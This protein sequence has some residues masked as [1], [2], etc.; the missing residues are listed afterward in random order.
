MPAADI[1]ALF[2]YGTLMRA[3]GHPM[4]M[5]LGS[6]SLYLGPGRIAARLYNLGSYP[7]AVPSDKARDSVHGDVVKL[8]RPAAT[9][10]WLDKYEGCG[11]EAPEPQAY[12]RVTAPVVLRAGESLNAWVYFYKMPVH[13]ARHISHGCYLA[14]RAMRV[15]QRICPLMSSE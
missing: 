11:A 7:G 10:A 9:L 15:Q 3:S 8:L 12:E 6:Q 13:R 5:R 2:V 4:A 14:G 1:R